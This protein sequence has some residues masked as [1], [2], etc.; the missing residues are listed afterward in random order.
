MDMAST[1]GRLIADFIDTSIAT[2]YSNNFTKVAF[3]LADDRIRCL[4]IANDCLI[5][6]YIY[7]QIWTCLVEMKLDLPNQANHLQTSIA[8]YLLDWIAASD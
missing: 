8:D 4:T 1:N 2:V 6:N 5:K 7:A 3:C